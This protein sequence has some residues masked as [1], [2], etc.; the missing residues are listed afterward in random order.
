M[1][2]AMLVTA[3]VLAQQSPPVFRGSWTATAGSFRTFHGSWSGQALPE[4]PNAAQGS[5][6]LVDGANRIVLQGTW[7]ADKSSQGWAG[8]WSARIVTGRSSPDR[9]VSGTWRADA[10]GSKG[11]TLADM[12]QG[13]LEREVVGSWVSGRLKG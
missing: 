10:A 7:A 4:R 5:W 1:L 9:V 8:R 12:L 11:K 2:A 6:A 3:G 13:T